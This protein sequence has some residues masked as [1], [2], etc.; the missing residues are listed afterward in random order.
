MPSIASSWST[1]MGAGGL[2]TNPLDLYR[3][4]TPREALRSFV[5]AAEHR[6]YDMVLRLAPE[7]WAAKLTPTKVKQSWE[8]PRKAE[9]AQM[10]AR[11][12]RNLDQPIRY[13]GEDK[14]VMPYGERHA[15]RFL[16]EGQLWKID[17]PD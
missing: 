14:A 15:V 10:L 1:V 3:Q 8:G 17:D 13:Q 4:G 12:K 9:I 6:R 16:R 2:R 5:R 11:L 7:R